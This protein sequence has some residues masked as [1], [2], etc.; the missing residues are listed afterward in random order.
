M[1]SVFFA[2]S[3]LFFSSSSFALTDSNGVACETKVSQLVKA[4]FQVVDTPF[5]FFVSAE[6]EVQVLSFQNTTP[7]SYGQE[8]IATVNFKFN[9]EWKPKADQKLR[10]KL[11]GEFDCDYLRV[12]SIKTLK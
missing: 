8:Y 2:L 11:T 9:R 10:L 3:L 12:K 5:D 1:K 4:Y 7:G 6:D